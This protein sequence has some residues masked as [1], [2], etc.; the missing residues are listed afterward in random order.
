LPVAFDKWTLTADMLVPN[1]V[2]EIVKTPFKT[3]EAETGLIENTEEEEMDDA[4]KSNDVVAF[5]LLN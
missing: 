2:P 1:P 4:K 5:L 3:G